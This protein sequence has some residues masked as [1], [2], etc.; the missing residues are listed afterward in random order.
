M[1]EK[2]LSFPAET[3]TAARTVANH[4]SLRPEYVQMFVLYGIIPD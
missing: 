3:P 4:S 2:F 1:S